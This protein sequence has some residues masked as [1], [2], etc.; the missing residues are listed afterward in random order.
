MSNKELLVKLLSVEAQI[1]LSK[2]KDLKFDE[3]EWK[4]IIRAGYRIT[5]A[6]DNYSPNLD[7]FLEFEQIDDENNE[8]Q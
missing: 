3:V 2:F 8:D 1:D 6:F 7:K 5:Q 4:K